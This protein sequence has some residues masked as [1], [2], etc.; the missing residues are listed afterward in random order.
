MKTLREMNYQGDFVLEAH[1]QM[2]ETTDE[3][4]WN[5]YLKEMMDASRQLIAMV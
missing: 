2:R 5:R 3:A 4:L 1:H